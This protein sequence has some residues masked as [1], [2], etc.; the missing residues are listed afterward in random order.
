VRLSRRKG[1]VEVITARLHNGLI[2]V[3]LCPG[4]SLT[5]RLRSVLSI[6]R[7]IVL[8]AMRLMCGTVQLPT[9]NS[10]ILVVIQ[11]SM[12]LAGSPTLVICRTVGISYLVSLS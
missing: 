6:Q 8:F 9:W 1:A 12:P 11:R 10:I 3:A 7:E 2:R 4:Q 5:S